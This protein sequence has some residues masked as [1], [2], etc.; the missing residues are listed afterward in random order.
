MFH[1]E[2]YRVSLWNEGLRLAGSSFTR[3]K[4]VII[5]MVVFGHFMVKC[6]DFRGRKMR[7]FH[8]EHRGVRIGRHL[9][10]RHNVVISFRIFNGELSILLPRHAKC[11]SG[12]NAP[13]LNMEGIDVPRG[14]FLE[15]GI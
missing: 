12:W 14:T 1:V 9:L 13:S 6:G 7:M 10:R 15:F 11:P 4:D 5:F 2:H 8:V 3:Q